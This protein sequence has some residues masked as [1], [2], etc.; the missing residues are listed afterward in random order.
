WRATARRRRCCGNSLGRMP[1]S[2]PPSAAPALPMLI[3]SFASSVSS[4]T[5]HGFAGLAAYL[6]SCFGDGTSCSRSGHSPILTEG[7][8][9]GGLDPAVIGAW[10]TDDEFSTTS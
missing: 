7:S 3:A 5:S 6:V 2:G 1:P 8:P 9:E 4:L 10:S